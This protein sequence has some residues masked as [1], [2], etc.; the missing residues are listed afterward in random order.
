M[1]RVL[2]Q[3]IVTGL[4]AAAAI[5]FPVE[6][7]GQPSND[8][9]AAAQRGQ[10]L[11]GTKF[12]DRIAARGGNDFVYALAGRDWVSGGSGYDVIH[13]DAGP[14]RLHGGT[15]ADSIEGGRGNDRIHVGDDGR[16]DYVDCGPGDDVAWIDRADYE[17]QPLFGCETLIPTEKFVRVPAA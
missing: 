8:D 9:V 2:S 5:G 12:D 11:V 4:L 10:V 6:G 16:A 13:G 3:V 17:T 15:G 1:R 14:D 7:L